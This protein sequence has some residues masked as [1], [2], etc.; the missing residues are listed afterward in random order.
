MNTESLTRSQRA[1]WLSGFAIFI[2]PLA[3]FL[4]FSIQLLL[5]KHLLPLYGGTPAVWLGSSL[6]F[7]LSLLLGYSWAV[8]LLARP[9]RMQT[10]AT[11]LLAVLAVFTLQLPATAT[12]NPSISLV[13]GRLAIGSLPAMVLLF[14]AAP[15]LHGWVERQA[16]KL[17]YHFY[18][19]SNAG[20]LIALISY[21]FLI[22]PV[23]GLSLQYQGWKALFGIAAAAFAIAGC[24][25]WSQAAQENAAPR[26]PAESPGW[27]AVLA[28]LVLAALGVLH[29][30]GAT[31]QI[32][33][34][35]GSTPL[36]WAGPLGLY[37][38]GFALTFSGRWQTWMTRAA[39]VAL[40]IALGGFMVVKG[41]N[42]ATIAGPRLIWLLGVSA[43]GGFITSALLHHLRPQRRSDLFY[44]ALGAG[45]TLGGLGSTYV[46]PKLFP[47]PV[48]VTFTSLAILISG[49]IWLLPEIDRL[50]RML[51]AVVVATPVLI[52]GLHQHLLRTEGL[53]ALHLR[54]VTGSILVEFSEGG[55][56]LSSET[57]TH[58]S[59]LTSDEFS[60]RHPTLYYTE[61]SG[62]GRV[63]TQLQESLPSMRYGVV[64]L[65]AGTLA[66][67]TRP[68]DTCDF[69]D[70]DSKAVFVAQEYFS[71][72][73]DAQGTVTVTLRDGRQALEKSTADY[74]VLIIDAF[75]GDH[76]PPHLLTREAMRVYTDR[77]SARNGVLL[78]HA[79]ARHA[80]YF[81]PIEATARSLGFVAFKVTT[82]IEA[83]REDADFEATLSEYIV[84]CPPTRFIEL[85]LWFPDEEDDGRVHH[86]VLHE[87]SSAIDPRKIWT[88]DHNS[89]LQTLDLGS[90]IRGE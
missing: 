19:L 60:R 18:A 54:D 84:I 22:E 33:G 23:F 37:L 43:S 76:V 14:S 86:R 52:I 67:Y 11:A 31:N 61:S 75:Q 51:L 25:L 42:A 48:E 77:L 69:W 17:P 13:V 68:E 49:L 90:W 9:L 56:V 62:A 39:I 8:W 73:R 3:A 53:A 26:S 7:Q 63:I 4:G 15:L 50:R 21:P 36:A 29:L 40:A 46:I 45:G 80:D 20:S 72:L 89:T 28:W 5:A 65:G 30:L 70:I 57:T 38:L 59:Q 2:A 83:P 1:E 81:P 47:L 66:A 85:A 82:Q 87:N 34:E 88:D 79:S 12:E 10:W 71:Y 35:I 64:G 32:A 74:D 16:G 55:V 24:F 78:V 44:L 41:F 6:Y 27:K 58:G